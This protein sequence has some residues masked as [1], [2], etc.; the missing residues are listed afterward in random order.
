MQ[1]APD[2]NQ[3]TPDSPIAYLCAEFA[4]SDDLPIYSGGL[5]ILAGDM[6]RQASQD[7]F[8]LVAVGL[9]YKEGYFRQIL[10][11]EGKQEEQPA[12]LDTT[13]SPIHKLTT[14]TGD[15]FR[16]KIYIRERTIFVEVWEYREKEINSSQM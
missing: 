5:G 9:L 6:V 15:P 10:S 16:L 2:N 14:A 13:L 1:I 8:P 4:M 11:P 7:G 3:I 12:F